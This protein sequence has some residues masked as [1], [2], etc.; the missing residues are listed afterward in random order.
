MPEIRSE[1]SDSAMPNH[2]ANNHRRILIDW[3][4]SSAAS[5]V[6]G[7]QRVVLRLVA[8]AKARENVVQPYSFL[9]VI[10]SGGEIFEYRQ[11]TVSVCKS[12]PRDW[13]GRFDTIIARRLP[14]VRSVLARAALNAQI[15][16]LLSAPHSKPIQGAVSYKPVAGDVLFL[17]D[18][19]WLIPGWELA[20]KQFKRSGGKVVALIY[21]V[22][23]LTHPSFCSPVF[24]AAFEHCLAALTRQ[25]DLFLTIS[26]T[27]A[28]EFAALAKKKAWRPGPL[29]P[30]KVI[31]LGSDF[32]DESHVTAGDSVDAEKESQSVRAFAASVEGFC[33][34]VG[35]IEMPR[36]NHDLVL[37]AM[38]RYWA[39]HGNAGLLIIG[40]P[41][42]Q[43]AEVIDRIAKL[44]QAGR[45]IF[46]LANATDGDLKAAY[47]RAACL[48]FPSLAEG[49]GLPIVEAITL[50]LPVLASD[51]PVHREVGGG[52]VEYFRLGDAQML[53]QMI[54]RQA[55]RS[56]SETNNL[57]INLHLPSWAECLNVIEAT[58]RHNV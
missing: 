18:A 57:C 11:P 33:L 47:S 9:P 25:S 53:A 39:N 24:S 27:S 16:S 41:G 12:W 35:S 48:L 37:D 10:L 5:S 22:L 23:P 13:L 38:Q 6:T 31:P 21:D 8:T 4:S 34:M 20:V 58:I 3:T 29:P 14:R 26:S 42:W 17:A 15:L 7:I 28:S 19:T 32:T 46:H 1:S 43:S 54:A 40:R 52:I 2:F 55:A 51:I 50:G 45:P 49:F 30:V 44:R 56:R 36:K